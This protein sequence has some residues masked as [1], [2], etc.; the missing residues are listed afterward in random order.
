MINKRNQATNKADRNQAPRLHGRSVL[1][2]DGDRG[3]EKA[4]RIFN[5]K[6]DNSRILKDLREK[7][8]YEK[9]SAK[10]KRK[11]AAARARW[12]REQA[13]SEAARLQFD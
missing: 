6:V 11:R 1:V 12:I 10:R 13:E 2:T 4:L 9:P 3:F 5:R 7:E 8:F